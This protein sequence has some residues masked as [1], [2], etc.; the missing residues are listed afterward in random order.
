MA[1]INMTVI[2]VN[3]SSGEIIITPQNSN[4]NVVTLNSKILKSY[5]KTLNPPSNLFTY[6]NSHFDPC[7]FSLSAGRYNYEYQGCSYTSESI[8]LAQAEIENY[9]ERKLYKVSA[10]VVYYLD[11]VSLANDYN[12]TNTLTQHVSAGGWIPTQQ[13][14]L[15]F[16]S[17]Y[18]L[19]AIR[20]PSSKSD[21]ACID[22]YADIRLPNNF[23]VEVYL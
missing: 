11:L 17:H 13:L 22:F 19:T 8:R 2:D 14:A 21:G 7:T 4:K 9:N 15:P 10:D 20:V 18:G 16:T 12:F 3:L 1:D 6:K 5:I 23:F